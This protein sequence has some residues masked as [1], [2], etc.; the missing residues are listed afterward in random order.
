M[1]LVCAQACHCCSCLHV[2]ACTVLQLANSMACAFRCAH[3]SL[4]PALLGCGMLCL[5][6]SCIPLMVMAAAKQLASGQG[7]K[8]GLLGRVCVYVCVCMCRW[9]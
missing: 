2:L 8:N 5:L 1:L 3:A 4:E 7:F 6:P 9:H